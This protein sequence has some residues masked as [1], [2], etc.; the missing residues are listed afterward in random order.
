[1]SGDWSSDVCS[2]SLY[3]ITKKECDYRIFEAQSW[4]ENEEKAKKQT[5]ARMTVTGPGRA[6]PEKCLIRKNQTD[7]EGI[8]ITWPSN[9]F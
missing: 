8:L 6:L 3:N 7:A 2:T 9:F 5:A 1:M 4:S